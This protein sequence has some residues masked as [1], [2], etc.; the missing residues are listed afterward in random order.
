MCVYLRSV[1]LSMGFP[2][3]EG[4]VPLPLWEDAMLS[5]I[6]GPLGGCP[7]QHLTWSLRRSCEDIPCQSLTWNMKMI[8]SKSLKGISFYTNP[9]HTCHVCFQGVDLFGCWG[10]VSSAGR[11]LSNRRMK[12]ISE[13]M[14]WCGNFILCFWVLGGLLSFWT[15]NLKLGLFWCY[16]FLFY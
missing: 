11:I 4:H 1:Y 5:L 8:V 15:L 6:A 10:D 9:K 16:R 2:T 14:H 13:W 12:E 7:H 3:K